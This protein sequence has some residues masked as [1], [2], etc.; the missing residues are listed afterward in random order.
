MSDPRDGT[1]RYDP[2]SFEPAMAARWVEEG[3]Y[4][5][6]LASTGDPYYALPMFPYPSGDLHM[7]HTEIF[8]IQYA[9]TSPRAK[10]FLQDCASSPDHYVDVAKPGAIDEAFDAIAG[11]ILSARITK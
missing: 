4:T 8:T 3:A 9:T 11:Q 6:D 1:E 7:G 2:T 10:A 5:L